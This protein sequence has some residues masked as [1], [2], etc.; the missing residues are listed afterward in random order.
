VTRRQARD[1]NK[2]SSFFSLVQVYTP[3]HG[4]IASLRLNKGQKIDL[5]AEGKLL[6]VL[7][8]YTTV[9]SGAYF[10]GD[11]FATIGELFCDSFTHIRIIIQRQVLLIGE[12]LLCL[13]DHSLLNFRIS[14]NPQPRV[15]RGILVPF[16]R[17]K[18]PHA[19]GRQILLNSRCGHPTVL[20]RG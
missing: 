6:R 1:S 11:A 16:C 10:S 5:A 17:T 15:R 4:C 14:S 8:C 12:L 9:E 20:Q 3:Y 2:Q 13:Y 7:N 19:D 18:R